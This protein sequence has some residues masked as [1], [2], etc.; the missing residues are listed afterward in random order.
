MILHYF[1]H[2]ESNDR[3]F[4]GFREK[5]NCSLIR[6][7]LLFFTLCFHSTTLLLILTYMVLSIISFQFIHYVEDFCSIGVCPFDNHGFWRLVV[8]D[9]SVSLCVVLSN[10]LNILQLQHAQRNVEPVHILAALREQENTMTMTLVSGHMLQILVSASLIPTPSTSNWLNR[11]SHNKPPSNS[12][13][14]LFLFI[15][16]E[17]FGL[18]SLIFLGFSGDGAV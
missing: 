9:F 14:E 15:V 2:V 10:F 11:F 8:S 1:L 12:K 6:Y 3:E 17:L 5:N 18:L 7:G 13:T 4:P 16:I